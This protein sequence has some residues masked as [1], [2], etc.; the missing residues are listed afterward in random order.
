MLFL[1]LSLCLAVSFILYTGLVSQYQPMYKNRYRHIYA[2]NNYAKHFIEHPDLPVSYEK[3]N[4]KFLKHIDEKAHIKTVVIVILSLGSKRLLESYRRW[5]N[6]MVPMN[7]NFYTIFVAYDDQA[8]VTTF[9]D[10]MLT[11]AHF[12]ETFDK[13]HNKTIRAMLFA[14]RY[15]EYDYILRTNLSTVWDFNLFEKLLDTL[16]LHNVLAGQNS[17]DRFIGGAGMLFS[18]DV[19]DIILEQSFHKG[20]Y[21]QIDLA[22]DILLT[23]QTLIPKKKW[24][25]LPNFVVYTDQGEFRMN[26]IL[27][28][29]HFYYRLKSPNW[30]TQG[31]VDI[32]D[33]LYLCQLIKARYA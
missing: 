19:V 30:N 15:L 14:R 25:H 2:T 33:G 11:L 10:H 6:Y 3:E 20:E 27:N 28:Q 26:D 21:V 12:P 9:R 18:K 17:V 31:H 7:P 13:I 29:E 16:P 5:V 24:I 1:F 4:I 32:K 8:E 22:D 23:D